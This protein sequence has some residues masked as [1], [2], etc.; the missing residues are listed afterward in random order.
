MKLSQ[1][2]LFALAGTGMAFHVKFQ[3]YSAA[4]CPDNFHIAKDTNLENGKC[5]TFDHH[6]PAFE[7]FR[8]W[9]KSEPEYL[10]KHVCKAVVHEG[11]HCDG[12]S[13]TMDGKRLRFLPSSLL[14]LTCLIDIS[15]SANECGHPPFGARSAS[16]QCEP[17]KFDTMVAPPTKTSVDVKSVTTV[18]SSAWVETVVST[19]SAST[20]TQSSTT[21]MTWVPKPSTICGKRSGCHAE[22]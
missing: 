8:A 2:V 22:V 10:Q 5:K 1:A 17:R 7:S 18:T 14:M 19:H 16:I 12:Q 6:E 4:N 13:F 21:I 3:R 11:W 15:V 9:V 20:E